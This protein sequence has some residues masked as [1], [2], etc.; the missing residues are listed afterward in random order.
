MNLVMNLLKYKKEFD[1]RHDWDSEEET[2]LKTN[3]PN[4]CFEN[5]PQAWIIPIDKILSKNNHDS[6]KEIKQYYGQVIVLPRNDILEKKLDNILKN[7]DI[8]LV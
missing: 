8:D 6:V 5:I 3:W 4:I 1:S 2:Q 7:I